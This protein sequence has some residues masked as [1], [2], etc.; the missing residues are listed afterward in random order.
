MTE[1]LFI[2]EYENTKVDVFSVS[3]MAMIRGYNV[4]NARQ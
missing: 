2:P 1:E 4:I 3:W